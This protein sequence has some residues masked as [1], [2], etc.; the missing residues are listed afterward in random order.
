MKKL[1]TILV[2][3]VLTLS[4]SF[5]GVKCVFITA[6]QTPD[7]IIINHLKDNGYDVDVFIANGTVPV[8]AEGSYALAVLSETIGST[9]TTWKAFTNAPL[10]FVA[11]KTFAARGHNSALKWLT[12]NSTG[13]DYA[14]TTDITVT[15]ADDTHPIMAD[16]TGT[17]QLLYATV[18][19]PLN[20]A[21]IYAL[22]WLKFPTLPTG[23]KV[24]T[25]ATIGTGTIYTVEGPLPQTIAFDRGTVINLSTLA[26]RA[27]ISGI[28]FGANAQLTPAGLKLIKQAC[29][30]VAAGGVATAV[31]P[32]VANSIL[33]KSGSELIN[34]T[35]LKVEVYTILGAHI[36]STSDLSINVE[37]LA[38][39]V[40]VAKTSAGVLKFSL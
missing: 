1:F 18:V 3:S 35:G 8:A 38:K 34:P 13:V 2:L 16:F 33:K 37:K 7:D 29:D 28:N 36:F 24:L 30:W 32:V 5:A 10:P 14:N 12:T 19:D 11:L 22:Q 23:A 27:V 40:Y 25:T 39:G 6:N 20:A 31:Q 15:I 9:A 26:N 21:N 4:T 17:P